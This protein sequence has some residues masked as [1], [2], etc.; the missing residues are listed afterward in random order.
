MSWRAAIVLLLVCGLN[1][2]ANAQTT[3]PSVAWVGVVQ[4]F[5]KSLA[6][7]NGADDSKATLSDDCGVRSFK[8]SANT[9]ATLAARTSGANVLLANAYTAPVTS[10]ASDVANS[11]GLASNVPDSVK[12]MFIPADGD[13]SKAD[14]VAALWMSRVLNLTDGQSA[15]LLIYLIADPNHPETTQPQAIQPQAMLVLIKGQADSDGAFHITQ[16]VFGD[17]QQAVEAY[18]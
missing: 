12:K 11:I 9:V 14:N 4:Q 15:G 10:L 17:P 8:D 3:K 5:A 2:L 16:I 7:P 6:D 13:T 1:A 18:H